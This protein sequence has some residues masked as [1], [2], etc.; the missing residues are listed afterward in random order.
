MLGIRRGKCISK[1]RAKP[2]YFD[3]RICMHTYIYYTSGRAYLV[4][5]ARMP[6]MD[7]AGSVTD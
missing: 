5:H 7:I 4:S 6:F 2:S 3:N 1:L